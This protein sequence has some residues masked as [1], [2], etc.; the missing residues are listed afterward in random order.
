[1][2]TAV[3]CSLL[4]LTLTACFPAVELL[5]GG[6]PDVAIGVLEFAP[7]PQISICF[8]GSFRIVTGAEK[9][10][11][12]LTSDAI[13]LSRFIGARIM[14]YG[15]AYSAICEGTLVRSCSSMSVAKVVP[16]TSTAVAPV[17][18]GL[19]KMIYR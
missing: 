10:D 12:Y 11:C 7:K 16:L 14:V 8:C 4:V 2:R 5:A 9:K 6:E 13:D 19:V 18:W 3:T 1:M 17:D 15:T